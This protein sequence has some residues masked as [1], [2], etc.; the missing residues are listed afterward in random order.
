MSDQHR[1]ESQTEIA[2]QLTEE[3][4]DQIQRVTGKLVTELKVATVEDRANPG[5]IVE[6]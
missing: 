1:K 3:Q 2:L 6:Y 5:I 4:R